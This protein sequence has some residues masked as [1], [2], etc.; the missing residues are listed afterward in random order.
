MQ[1]R[2]SADNEFM[3]VALSLAARNLGDTWPNPSVGCVLVKDGHV[4]GRGWTQSGGRPHAETEALARAGDK[5]RGATAYVTLEP[6]SHHGK[7]P[8]CA[9]ALVAAGV[10]RV[11]SATADPDTRVNGRGLARLRD[12]GIV[13]T[14]GVCKAAADRLNAGFFL[15]VGQGRPLFAL[16]TATSLDGRIA[17]ASGESRWITGDTARRAVHAVRARY[18]AILVG[19]ETALTDDPLLTCRMDGYEGRAKVRIVLDRRLRLAPNA[20]LVKTARE[21]PTWVITAEQSLA[22]PRS[23][24]LARSGVEVIGLTDVSDH[25]TFTIAVGKALADKGLTRVMIEGGG[26]VSAAF[27]RA[28]LVDEVAWFKAASVIGGDG[29]A[30]IYPMG[31]MNLADMPRFKVRES[32]KFGEDTLDIL[33]R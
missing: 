7:T 5:A 9:D 28:G 16:K 31:L 12:A 27:L 3:D 15:K 1:P 21:I 2:A 24:E 22:L 8:P 13:V 29:R 33:A 6:C 25:A 32:L 26:Q 20:A 4:V 30:S 17:L 18:D 14:E 19:S 11:V 10:S 23:A